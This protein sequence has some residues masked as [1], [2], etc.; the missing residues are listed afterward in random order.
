MNVSALDNSLKDFYVKYSNKK[1]IM[2]N[3]LEK[4]SF[5]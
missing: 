4:K 1:Q 5:C 2:K 3:G